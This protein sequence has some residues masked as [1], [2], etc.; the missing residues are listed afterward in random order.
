MELEEA[1]KKLYDEI[2]NIIKKNRWFNA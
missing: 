2:L 1:N